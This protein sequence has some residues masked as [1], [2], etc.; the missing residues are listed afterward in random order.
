MEAER[1]SHVRPNV[2]IVE[3]RLSPIKRKKIVKNP[4]FNRFRSGLAR[5]RALT[6]RAL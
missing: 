2:K 1:F 5:R 6:T 4:I 3:N